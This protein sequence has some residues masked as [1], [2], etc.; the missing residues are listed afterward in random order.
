MA[1]RAK[2]AEKDLLGKVDR[3]VS[4]AEQIDGQLDDHP[5]VF[6]HQFGERRVV[7]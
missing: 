4:I 1:D 5:L 3:L 7:A 6:G 2:D